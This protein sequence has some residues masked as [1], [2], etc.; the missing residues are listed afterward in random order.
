MSNFICSVCGINNIDCGKAGYKTA[1]EIELEKK[2][3]I[4]VQ[5]LEKYANT[6]TYDWIDS[7]KTAQEALAKI[8]EI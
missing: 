6:P 5:A 4:A 3:D 1:I 8:K 7:Q 2:L